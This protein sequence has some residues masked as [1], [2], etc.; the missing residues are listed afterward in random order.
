MYEPDHEDQFDLL[1]RLPYP[2]IL[3]W[4]WW[5]ADALSTLTCKLA[6]LIHTENYF[7]LLFRFLPNHQSSERCDTT[8]STNKKRWIDESILIFRS[9]HAN[10]KM[11]PAHMYTCM[12]KKKLDKQVKWSLTQMKICFYH[13]FTLSHKNKASYSLNFYSSSSWK[14]MNYWRIPRKKYFHAT[15]ICIWV[16]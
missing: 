10:S 1:C 15:N 6:K 5:C 3:S 12:R 14:W 8:T 9:C 16:S 4:E 2:Q 7:Q 13:L 11:H